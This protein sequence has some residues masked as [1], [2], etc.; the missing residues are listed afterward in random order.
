MN[1]KSTTQ[2]D[3]DTICKLMSHMMLHVWDEVNPKAEN[4]K[5]HTH[6]GIN[7][8]ANRMFDRLPVRMGD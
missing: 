1:R 6:K 2:C 7:Y 4:V 8:Y 3:H 5:A